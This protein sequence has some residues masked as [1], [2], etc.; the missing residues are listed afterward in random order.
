VRGLAGLPG[1]ADLAGVQVQVAAGRIVRVI[2]DPG[3]LGELEAG[4]GEHGDDRSVAPG[5]ERAAAAGFLYCR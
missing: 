2:A 1:D 3:Q 4:R 5:G